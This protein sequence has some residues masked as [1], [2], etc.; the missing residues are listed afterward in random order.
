MRASAWRAV[1]RASSA[2]K[3][4]ASTTDSSPSAVE[5]AHGVAGLFERAAQLSA[6]RVVGL[7]RGQ[8]GDRPGEPRQRGV[9]VAVQLPRA[10]PRGRPARRAARSA[11]ST[12]PPSRAARGDRGSWRPRSRRCWKLEEL[13]LL[14]ARAASPPRASR[15]RW[16]S[17]R[18]SAHRDELVGRHLAARVEEPQGL[19]AL[20]QRERIVLPVD[21]DQVR[22]PGPQRFGQLAAAVD[23]AAQP[24]LEPDSRGRA[25]SRRRRGAETTADT[26]VSAA[27]AW[28]D[29]APS[30]PRQSSRA[31]SRRVLPAPVSPVMTLKPGANSD[32]GV[33]DDAQAVGVEFE[34]LRLRHVPLAG[35]RAGGTRARICAV[36]MTLTGRRA[37]GAPRRTP[38]SR[39]SRWCARRRR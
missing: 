17:R 11:A 2:S 29:A 32:A 18:R 15:S 19:A 4:A 12:P 33:V 13:Q 16:A 24:T 36:A 28:R 27:T 1:T 5:V 35:S 3:A 8:V 26:L 20:A 25:P 22:G 31:P 38:R 21:D 23:R 39:A 9:A 37:A 6:R 7:T 10:P 30:E 34:Q 14:G